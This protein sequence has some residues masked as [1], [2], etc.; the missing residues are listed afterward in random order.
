MS[1]AV[2]STLA[3]V[4]RSARTE[5][6]AR[7]AA[8]RL[9]HPDLDGD[10][11]AEFVRGAVDPLVVA[12]EGVRPERAIDVAHVAYDMALELV[13]QKLVGRSARTTHVGDAWRRILPRVAPLVAT[14][15]ERVIAAVC[16]AAHQLSVT[17]GARPSFWIDTMAE[18][19]SECGDVETFLTLGHVV[20]WRAGMAHLRE[21]A[22]AA[23]DALP[24]P[25]VLAAIAAPGGQWAKIR[26]RLHADP[27][28]DPAKP[29]ASATEG[30]VVARAGAFRGFGGLF[31][32]PPVVAM[33]GEQL[34]VRGGEDCWLLKADAFGATFHRATKE[35]FECARVERTLP[36][37]VS[38]SG[39]ALTVRGVKAKVPDLVDDVS[40]ACANSTTLALTSPYMHAVVLVVLTSTE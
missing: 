2:S 1:D 33:A 5:L 20:A 8:A 23:A 27:W 25:L 40:S 19:A 15:P 39:G 35:E 18:L 21:S 10:V 6:N 34:L 31:T 17:T 7:F 22:L 12:V 9:R 36:T 4:L 3:A 29:R 37:G 24:E 11:F 28:F 16:N 14:T 38:L 30:R 13:G 32:E 26:D